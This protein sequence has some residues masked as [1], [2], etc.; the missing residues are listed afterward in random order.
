MLFSIYF[1][2]SKHSELAKA[3]M[4]IPNI[5]PQGSPHLPPLF[6]FRVAALIVLY[7]LLPCHSQQNFQLSFNLNPN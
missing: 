2:V 7:S 6:L 4:V 1:I 3:A 5:S